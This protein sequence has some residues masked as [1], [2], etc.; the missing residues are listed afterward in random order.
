MVYLI[1]LC[2][3]LEYEIPKGMNSFQKLSKYF[4]LSGK[5]PK[6]E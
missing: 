1:V 2:V 4:V 3:T 6:T 5:I